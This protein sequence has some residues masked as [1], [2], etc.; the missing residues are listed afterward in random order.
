MNSVKLAKSA[1]ITQFQLR[2]K[3]EVLGKQSEKEKTDRQLKDQKL[4][5]LTELT[6][7]TNISLLEQQKRD[8]EE[9]GKENVVSAQSIDE[10]LEKLTIDSGVKFVDQHPERRMKAAYKAYESSQMPLL[11]EE[12]P[13]LKY[14]QLKERLWQNWLKSPENP[15]VQAKKA[16][17]EA[18]V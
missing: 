3:N 13:T 6:P 1:K 2:Q 16:Q 8:E 9:F 12:F 14:S 5:P 7:N 10:A 4:L 15:I 18:A 11:K 17:M